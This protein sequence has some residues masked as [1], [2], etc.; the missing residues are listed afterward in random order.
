MQFEQGRRFGSYEIVSLIGIGGMGQVYRAKDLQLG[1]EVAIKFLTEEAAGNQDRLRRFI[2]EAKATSALNHPNILTVYTIGE[3]DD[4]PYLITE[5]VDGV[6]LRKLLAQGSLPLGRAIEIAIQTL[7]GL[8][9]AHSIGIVH[10]DLKPENLMIT[11]D[12][13]VKILDFGLAKLLK[14][15][16]AGLAWEWL[17]HNPREAIKWYEKAYQ[18]TPGY[19][20]VTKALVDCYLEADQKNQAVAALQRYM[21]KVR[22]GY[23][24]QQAKQRLTH[25]TASAA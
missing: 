22:S 11:K 4:H 10:R 7:T 2:A 15:N 5:L 8:S 9:K 21:D 14:E 12:G 1:R 25:I 3:E 20:P 16:I 6:T 24:Y 13:F 18:L 19:Y 17:D 23:G